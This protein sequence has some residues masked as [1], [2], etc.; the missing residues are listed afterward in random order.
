MEI[1]EKVEII[2]YLAHFTPEWQEPGWDEKKIGL[3]RRNYCDLR[4]M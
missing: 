4:A 2:A 1:L 3:A